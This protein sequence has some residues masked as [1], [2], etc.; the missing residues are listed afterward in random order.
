MKDYRLIEVSEICEKNNKNCEECEFY[1]EDW[2]C[3]E[4]DTGFHPSAWH[5]DKENKKEVKQNERSK[6]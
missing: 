5:I 6:N 1:K 2:R 3:C 4:F